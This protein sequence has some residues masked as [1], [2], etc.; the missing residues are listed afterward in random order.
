MVNVKAA[1]ALWKLEVQ[2]AI[3]LEECH[4]Q[5]GWT[6]RQ[7]LSSIGCLQAAADLFDEAAAVNP[8]DARTFLQKALLERRMGDYE[9]TRRWSSTFAMCTILAVM[10][11]RSGRCCPAC[12]C[13][14]ST[15]AL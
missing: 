4:T 13:L 15:F 7:V 8:N 9:A 14:H 6:Q 11:T 3:V 5:H 10:K 2:L 1:D 12:V